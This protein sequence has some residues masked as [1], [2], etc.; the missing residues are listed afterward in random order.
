VPRAG[1]VPVTITTSDSSIVTLGAGNTAQA[2]LEAGSRVVPVT[3]TTTG[4]PGTAVL[5]FAFGG[6]VR[7]LL[8]VVGNP[9]ASELPTI[10]AAPVCV[11]TSATNTCKADP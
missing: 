2:T 11:S 1:A 5:T 8:V 4:T 6:E 9:P 10:F 7:Q 3:F